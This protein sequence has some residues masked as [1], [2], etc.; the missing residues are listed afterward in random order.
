MEDDE[1]VMFLGQSQNGDQNRK[2]GG[3]SASSHTTSIEFI[4]HFNTLTETAQ[5]FSSKFDLRFHSMGACV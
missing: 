1:E 2:E 5:Y 3:S 4:P